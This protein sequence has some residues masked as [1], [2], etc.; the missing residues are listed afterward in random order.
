M[1]A[2][3]TV[4]ELKAVC[5]N[6]HG[7]CGTIVRLENGVVTEVVGDPDNPINQGK[8]CVKA[9]AST[10]EQLYHPDRLDYP[11]MRAGARGEGKWRRASWEEALS[12]I[13]SQD[14]RDQ[15]PRTAPKPSPS[16]AAWA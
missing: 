16:R 8:L 6:C 9:G 13:S 12:A 10:I 14:A 4:S 2:P 1:N 5:R 11:L 7:G 3:A 15:E